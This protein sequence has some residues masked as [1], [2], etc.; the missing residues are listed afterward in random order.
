MVES[1]AGDASAAQPLIE[2]GC[3]LLEALIREN[4]RATRIEMNLAWAYQQLAAVHLSSGRP[5]AALAEFNRGLQIQERLAH[6]YP[7]VP[8]FLTTCSESY[9]VLGDSLV[10]AGYEAQAEAAYAKAVDVLEVRM[11]DGS[12]EALYRKALATSQAALHHQQGRAAQSRRDY[13]AAA[14]SFAAA[15]ALFARRVW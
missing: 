4:P 14:Q 5:I 12:N 1:Y 9:R 3:E 7:A 8:D 2:D 13:E 11:A 10:S 6:E 15:L